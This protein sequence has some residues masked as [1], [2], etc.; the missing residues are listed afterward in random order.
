[1]EIQNKVLI[2]TS[3]APLNLEKQR[4][5]VDTWLKAGFEVIS[6][7][8]E[9]EINNVSSVFPD[10]YF[11]IVD[12][13]AKNIY[14]KPYIYIY[15]F[16]RLLNRQDYKVCGIVNSDICFKGVKENFLDFIYQESLGS[17]VYGHRKDVNNINE[18][19]GEVCEGVDYF[20]FDKK[21]TSIYQ[22]EGFCM[23]QPAWDYWMVAVPVSLNIPAKR[24]LNQIAYHEKHSQ[25][26]NEELNRFLTT[27][28]INDKYIKK[29]Y[30]SYNDAQL[31]GKL[32]EIV[33]LREGVIYN[34]FSKKPSVL[35]VYNPSNFKNI[36]TSKTYKSI[37]KQSYNNIKIIIDSIHNINKRE[38]QQDYICFVEE[39]DY[40]HPQFIELLINEIDN[41]DCVFVNNESL[42]IF[43]ELDN[44]H[45]L[46]L[47]FGES[48]DLL[49]L[50]KGLFKTS[51]LIEINFDLSYLYK[52]RKKLYGFRN[53]HHFKTN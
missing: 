4:R 53:M 39:G 7:N 5:A 30:P 27:N 42:N 11:H 17:L 12:R 32:S 51:K 29:L 25:Q 35:V 18:I 50:K 20:F 24:V 21:L 37:K 43:D 14:G 33:C 31:T 16:M 3:I 2:A 28:V 45:T 13:N 19:N 23:G 26:W 44:L 6:L 48:R 8:N 15:D 52:L 1:M 40:L 34:G 46:H 10:I 49:V 22:D 36:P 41:F 47:L 38:I 9:D